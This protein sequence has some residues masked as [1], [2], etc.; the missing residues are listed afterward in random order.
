MFEDLV[1]VSSVLP[2]W[3]SI[4][5]AVLLF[6]FVPAGT[7]V[8]NG[9]LSSHVVSDLF[10][11]IIVGLVFK[12]IIP[13]ALVFGGLTNLFKR[14]KSAWIFSGISKNGAKETLR[15]LSWKDFELLVSEHYKRKVTELI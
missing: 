9:T 12:Y 15:Q 1:K 14:G 2:W 11:R 8:P 5:V 10:I 6:V 13:L 4:G 7:A 3:L